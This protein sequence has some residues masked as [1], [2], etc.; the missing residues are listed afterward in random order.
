MV[1]SS[2]RL[3]MRDLTLLEDIYDN[4]FLSFYQ[5]HERHFPE[6]KRPTV[7]NRLSKLIR[8]KILDAINVNLFAHHRNNELIG[9]IYKLSKNGLKMLQEYRMTV[10]LNPIP[11]SL[12]LSCLFHDL[13]LTDALRA[14]KVKLPRLVMINSKVKFRDKIDTARIPDAFLF[15]PTTK[16]NVALELELTAKSEMRYRDIVLSYRTNEEFNRVLYIV[17]DQSIQKKIGGVI[18]GFM[19]SYDFNDDTDKFLFVTLDQLFKHQHT[20]VLNELQNKIYDKTMRFNDT[21]ASVQWNSMPLGF[22]TN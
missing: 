7:Y 17:K 3:T 9:V 8:A 4:Q 6:N 12:N 1:Q 10:N 14:L 2:V 15:D 16:I 18:T 22:D 21:G 11:A 13:L 5:I 20:E 19:K